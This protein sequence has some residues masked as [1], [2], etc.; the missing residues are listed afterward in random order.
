MR[1]Q[2][3][4]QLQNERKP[5]SLAVDHGSEPLFAEAPMGRLGLSNATFSLWFFQFLFLP[6]QAC[7]GGGGLYLGILH[8]TTRVFVQEGKVYVAQCLMLAPS[9]YAVSVP[10]SQCLARYPP[11][12]PPAGS[13]DPRCRS[14]G[15]SARPPP[16]APMAEVTSQRK[17]KV[18]ASFFK[19]PDRTSLEAGAR[20]ERMGGG[21][22][23][24]TQ[25]RG[26]VEQVSTNGD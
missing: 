3:T 15:P 17:L 25:P 4:E 2:S 6:E 14:L 19:A 11:H 24:P 20:G 9:P 21:E 16:A 13:S 10:F 7:R 5:V 26:G 23:S 18:Q 22:V 1:S 12:P 8:I